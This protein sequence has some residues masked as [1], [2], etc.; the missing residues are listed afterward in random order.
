MGLFQKNT[1]DSESGDVKYAV[2][3]NL[4]ALRR[5][6]LKVVEARKML[7]KDLNAR[8]RHLESS[9]YD[10][11]LE[12]MEHRAKVFAEKGIDQDGHLRDSELQSWMWTWHTKLVARLKDE[13]AR[14]EK[15][16]KRAD[17]N[18]APYMTL[19]DPAKLSL[20]TILEIMRL[21]GSGG[22]TLGMKTTRSLIAVGKAIENEYKA[23]MCRKH[24]IPMPDLTSWKPAAFFSS[25]GYQHL[26][27]RRLAAARTMQDA[28]AW[29]ATWSQ[30]TRS[31]V[32]AILVE[33]LMEVAEVTR[34]KV[35]PVTHELL[36][37]QFFFWSAMI[38]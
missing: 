9:V 21:Q 18:M 23:Q 15:S 20:L 28:E 8:Q 10:L 17:L 31:Q 16:T 1:T 37:V 7:D 34:M 22:I 36:Y 2:P 29:S 32:G 27:Q 30:T 13:I 4:S 14:I 5:H 6:L 35:D 11:A 3:F 38:F 12:Q 26:H 33:C 19:V 25:M 24:D